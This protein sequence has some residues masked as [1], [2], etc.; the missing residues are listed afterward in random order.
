MF[1][2]N[3][4]KKAFTCQKVEAFLIQFAKTHLLSVS[5]SRL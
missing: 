4:H 5:F 3:E 2:V 1:F